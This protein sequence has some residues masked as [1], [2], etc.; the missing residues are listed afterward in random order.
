MDYDDW[1]SAYEYPPPWDAT[2][3]H[4]ITWKVPARASATSFNFC[5]QKV[6]VIHN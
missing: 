2:R 3:L 6:G 5:V 1:G 4:S